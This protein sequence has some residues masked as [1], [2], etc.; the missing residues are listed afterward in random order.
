MKQNFKKYLG[1][2]AALAIVMSISGCEGTPEEIAQEQKKFDDKVAAIDKFNEESLKNPIVVGVTKNGNIV[3][4]AHLKYPDY[5][6]RN[7]YPDNHYVYMIDGNTSDNYEYRS[8]KTRKQKVEVFLNDKPTPEQVI[9]EA[10]RL[11]NLIE[12][13]KK[14]E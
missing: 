11:K 9:A 3:T 5:D 14:L 1:V 8:G 2:F 7:C 10:E 6:C 4:R 12:E 13:N